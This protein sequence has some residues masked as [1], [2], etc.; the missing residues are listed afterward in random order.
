MSAYW[1]SF[2]LIYVTVSEIVCYIYSSERR[3]SSGALLQDFN[4][5]MTPLTPLKISPL[6]LP[7][8]SPKISSQQP[9]DKQLTASWETPHVVEL[10]RKPGESLGISIVGGLQC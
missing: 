3:R 4:D 9:G 10:V 8:S 6:L 7:A 2:F 5:V 1:L